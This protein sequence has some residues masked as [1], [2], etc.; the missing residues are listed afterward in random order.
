[1]ESDIRLEHCWAKTDPT[2][3]QPALTVRDHC[4]IVGAVAEAV[5]PL[6]SGCVHLRFYFPLCEHGPGPAVPLDPRK[7]PP[8]RGAQA[9]RWMGERMAGY[10]AGVSVVAGSALALVFFPAGL[11]S[12]ATSTTASAAGS[13]AAT[14]RST[15]TRMAIGAESLMRAPSLVIRQ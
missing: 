15:H 6:C 9:V 5:S 7:K 11:T 1:M 8:V 3:G 10:S 13:V 4:V 12:A 14:S 2:T